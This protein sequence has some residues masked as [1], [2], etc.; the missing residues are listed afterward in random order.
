MFSSEKKRDTI[1]DILYFCHN[2]PGGVSPNLINVINFT[3]FEG[4]PNAIW[5]ITVQNLIENCFVD[6]ARGISEL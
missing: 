1:N 5:G 4:F 3:V 6:V 2:Y